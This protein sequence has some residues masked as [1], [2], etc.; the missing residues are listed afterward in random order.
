M[1][2][3]LSPFAFA[4]QLGFYAASLLLIGLLLARALGVTRMQ[5]VSVTVILGIVVMCF[6]AARLLLANAMLGGALAV[7]F[8]P[9]T[10]SWIWQAYK[11]QAYAVMFGCALGVVGAIGQQPAAMLAAAFILSAGFGLAGHTQGLESPSVFP[12]LAGLH[13]LIAGFWFGAPAALWPT[14]KMN[15]AE[16]VRRLEAFSHIAQFGIPTL[17]VA[18]LA[19]AWRLADGW[20]GLI[21]SAYGRLL[22][23]KLI[24]ASAALALGALN[25]LWVTKRVKIDPTAGRSALRL[26]LSVEFVLFLAAMGL[27]ALATTVQGPE[28]E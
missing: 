14:P 19:L 6:Y 28:M 9:A 8:D 1:P 2:D 24:V 16:L 4:I 18:G 20:T 5:G 10:F 12:W 15:Q 11:I 17:F 22:F 13:V 21:G 7:A 27:I 3:A 23:A 25:K 26:T